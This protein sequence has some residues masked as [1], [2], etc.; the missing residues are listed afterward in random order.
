MRIWKVRKN[1]II[2]PRQ[3]GGVNHV[4]DGCCRGVQL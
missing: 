4:E 2:E 3:F 1:G